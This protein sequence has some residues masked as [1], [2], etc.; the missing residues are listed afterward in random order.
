M[1]NIAA[2]APARRNTAANSGANFDTNLRDEL[3]DTWHS[4]N[5]LDTDFAIIS[6]IFARPHIQDIA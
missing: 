6:I 3:R 2:T 1:L 4:K 5:K